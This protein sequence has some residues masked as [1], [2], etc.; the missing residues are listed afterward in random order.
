MTINPTIVD[1]VAD[2]VKE[3]NIRATEEEIA[4]M[5]AI[6]SGDMLAFQDLCWKFNIPDR[7]LFTGA[8]AH[9]V[10]QAERRALAA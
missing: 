8:T 6:F 1:K 3:L 4:T 9:A 7:L 10:L 2:K 5:T